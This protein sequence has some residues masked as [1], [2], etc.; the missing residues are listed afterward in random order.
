MGKIGNLTIL[1]FTFYIL[2]LINA[3]LIATAFH[4]AVLALGILTTEI[5]NTIM[6]YRDIT[7]MGTVPIDIYKEPLR[8]FL[9]FIIPVGVMM[10]FPAKALMGLLSAQMVIFSFLIS[11]IFLWG[12]LRFWKYALKHY[13][14]ASS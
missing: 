3:F 8:G 7:R 9:T 10:T 2:L 1:N 4:I 5:D 14:S 13:S 11:G 12:S 6:L